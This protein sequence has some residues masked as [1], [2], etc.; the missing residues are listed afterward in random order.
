M[1]LASGQS[2]SVPVTVAA[3]VRA[4]HAAEEIFAAEICLEC[5]SADAAEPMLHGGSPSGGG[6]GAQTV[7]GRHAVLPV[8]AHVQPSLQVSQVQFR[9]LYLPAAA[10]AEGGAATAAVAAGEAAPAESTSGNSSS[11]FE[12]RAV[13]EV[14]VS[15]RGRWPLQVRASKQR[16]RGGQHCTLC[17]LPAQTRCRL[18]LSLPGLTKPCFVVT[19]ALLRPPFFDYPDT[20]VL[21]A[22]LAGPCAGRCNAAG[23]GGGGRRAAAAGGAA[24]GRGPSLRRH[25]AAGPARHSGPA[26]GS[27]PHS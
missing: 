6:G 24:R 26:P 22:G 9:E 20:Y 14:S 18:L 5:V 19:L 21:L 3:G 23:G 8:Q 17:L 27:Q 25:A 12:R 11:S 13:I 1:P 7:L 2:C 4:T 10:A 16:A 15:N